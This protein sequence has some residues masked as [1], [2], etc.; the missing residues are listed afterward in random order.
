MRIAMVMEYHPL[1]LVG[2]S[3]IQV[4]EVAKELAARGHNVTYVCQRYDRSRPAEEYIDGV[5][6]ARAL[7]WRKVLQV[8]T[9]PKLYMTLRRNRPDVVYQRY[10]SPLTGLAALS[11]RLLR[12]PFVWGCSEDASLE[13][14]FLRRHGSR[15]PRTLRARI[16]ARILDVDRWLADVLF[17]IG[18]RM[19]QAV[20]VQNKIQAELLRAYHG[21]Q[22]ETIPNGIRAGEF[23]HSE[24]PQ[25]LILWLNRIAERK[26]PQAFIRLAR[27]VALRR[28]NARFVLVGSRQQDDYMRSIRDMADAVPALELVGEVPF[29]ET[30]VWFGQ[31]WVFVLTSVGEGFPNVMLQAW[32][33][34]TPVVSLN[35]DP[36]ELLATRGLGLVCA[37]EEQLA[38]HVLHLLDD[39]EAR[40]RLADAGRAYVLQ[41]FEIG[42]VAAQYEALFARLVVI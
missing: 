21:R 39:A 38:A 22:G 33:A 5:W 18:L 2:G 32:A 29:A 14:G 41:H 19:A 27:A 28:P 13:P 24:S 20:V 25:P 11:A 37:D 7:T 17:S 31:A 23:H 15:S 34:G 8:L 40:R 6:V 36:D 9:G 1:D 3:Q 10:V 35:V 4:F 12:V 42:S 16:K 30:R 26:N